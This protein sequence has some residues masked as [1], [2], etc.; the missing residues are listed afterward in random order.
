MGA[1]AVLVLISL[2]TSSGGAPIPHTVSNSWEGFIWGIG[3][4]V[5]SLSRL[6]GILALALLSARFVRGA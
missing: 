2:W 4:P 6:A 1:M 5:I 3:Y